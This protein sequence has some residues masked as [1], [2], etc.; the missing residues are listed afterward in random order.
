MEGQATNRLQEIITSLAPQ[1]ALAEGDGMSQILHNEFQ[2][3]ARAGILFTVGF[4][5][6]RLH[7][8]DEIIPEMRAQVE[9]EKEPEKQKG[10]GDD[11]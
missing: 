2:K 4:P 8:L 5:M 1:A 7:H 10:N 9:T 11:E 3:G 6:A